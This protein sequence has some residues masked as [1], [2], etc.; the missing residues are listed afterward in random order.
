M[1]YKI[2]AVVKSLELKTRAVSARKIS[3][4]DVEWTRETIGWFVTFERSHEALFV[5][6][7][8]PF[9]LEVGSKVNIILEPVS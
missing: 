8:R 3:E 1:T 2:P 7:D 9:D 6:Y 5:G 4:T